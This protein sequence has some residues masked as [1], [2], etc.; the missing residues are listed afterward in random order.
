MAGSAI[1]NAGMDIIG[2]SSLMA[3]YNN[4]ALQFMIMFLFVLGGM[5]FG[6]IYDFNHYLRAR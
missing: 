1:N 3:Y 5:G 4:Y 2:G 6:I